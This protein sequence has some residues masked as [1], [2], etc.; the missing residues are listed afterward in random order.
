MNMTNETLDRI[1]EISAALEDYALYDDTEVGEVCLKLIQISNYVS[2]LDD[3]FVRVLV[4]EMDG[5]LQSYKEGATLVETEE[6]FTR[7]VISLV[8]E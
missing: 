8:W 3:T 1:R 2:Y 4:D 6:T 5:H 7:K